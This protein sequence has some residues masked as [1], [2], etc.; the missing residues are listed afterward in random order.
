MEVR[1]MGPPGEMEAWIR[2]IELVSRVR[3]VGRPY[4]NRDSADVR[5]FIHADLPDG[6]V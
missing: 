3:D 1:L 2:A 5:V 4:P 6:N